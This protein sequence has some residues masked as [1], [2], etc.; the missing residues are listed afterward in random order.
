MEIL[1]G[2]LLAINAFFTIG[3]PIIKVLAIL[4]QGDDQIVLKQSFLLTLL[5]W[6]IDAVMLTALILRLVKPASW[7]DNPVYLYVT[8]GLTLFGSLLA[9]RALRLQIKVE[10]DGLNVRTVLRRQTFYS[11][12]DL[13]LS[14]K[15]SH[16]L[17]D[18]S[19]R[20]SHLCTLTAK[21]RGISTMIRRWHDAM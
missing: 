19:S 8:L 2:I 11:Y 12:K 18:I 16:Q 9:L 3:T 17:V 10:K 15:F 7:P 21:K 20:S 13:E 1:F 6:G 14:G 5:G 4:K